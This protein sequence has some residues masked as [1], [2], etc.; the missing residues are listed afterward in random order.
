MT[1][2]GVSVAQAAHDLDLH[3][4][5]VR[6]WVKEFGLSGPDAFPGKGQQKP[7]DEELRSVRREVAKLKEERKSGSRSSR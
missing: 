6:R 2:H 7:D 1:V 3:T 5:I 4:T